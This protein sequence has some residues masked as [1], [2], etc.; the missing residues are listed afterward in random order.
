MSINQ[1]E[2]LLKRAERRVVVEVLRSHPQWT[3]D[4]LA[5][6][7]DR[8]GARALVL[9]S[10]TV[11]ELL[12]DVFPGSEDG[13]P[14]ISPRRLSAASQ[15]RGREFDAYVREVIAEA[16][17]PVAASYLRARVGG[18]RWKLQAALGRLILAGLVERRG[19]TSA[20]SSSRLRFCGRC[21]T[22]STPWRTIGLVTQSWAPIG[23]SNRRCLMRP[24]GPEGAGIVRLPR[25]SPGSY[26]THT[27]KD[28]GQLTL[29][30]ENHPLQLSWAWV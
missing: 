1:L 3:L 9:G 16:T 17:R 28:F 13:G 26:R 23:S 30:S 6:L 15:A 20:S 2:P 8:G 11:G 19:M 5:D 18:P 12:A 10:L 22:N 21:S 29:G 25:P 27:R 14:P 24:S 7:L 4:H